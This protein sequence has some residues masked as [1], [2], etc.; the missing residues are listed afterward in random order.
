MSEEVMVVSEAM[1]GVML[2]KVGQEEESNIKMQEEAPTDLQNLQEEA[3]VA[4]KA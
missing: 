1:E 2:D 4:P 3:K